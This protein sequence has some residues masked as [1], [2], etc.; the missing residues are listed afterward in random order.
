M[1][2]ENPEPGNVNRKG[3]IHYHDENNNKYMY[4][5]ETREFE[6]LTNR[7]FIKLIKDPKFVKALKYGFEILGEIF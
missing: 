6:G 5:F 2:V 4:N 1:E 7:E 3:Q